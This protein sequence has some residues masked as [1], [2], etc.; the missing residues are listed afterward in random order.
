MIAPSAFSTAPSILSFKCD[1]LLWWVLGA[2]FLTPAPV[3]LFLVVVFLVVV[4]G[5]VARVAVVLRFRSGV[6]DTALRMRGFELPVAARVD[7]IAIRVVGFAPN[8]VS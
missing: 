6:V 1:F 4:L 2:L 8:L 7:A 3:V 5:L